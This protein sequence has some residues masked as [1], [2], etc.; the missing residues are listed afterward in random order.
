MGHSGGAALLPAVL[1]HLD[2]TVDQAILV[3]G[4]WTPPSTEDEPVL[5]DTY[6]WAAIR[7]SARDLYFINS[8]NDPYGTASSASRIASPSWRTTKSSRTASVC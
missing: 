3:A 8:R 6:D 5:H 1:Q 7:G 2:A 4:S